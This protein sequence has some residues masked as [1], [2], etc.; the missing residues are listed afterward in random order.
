MSCKLS[1]VH[2]GVWCS[3]STG[4]SNPPGLGSIPKCP[5]QLR[6]TQQNFFD[7]N[8]SPFTIFIVS[9]KIIKQMK[10][11]L[12]ELTGTIVGYLGSRNI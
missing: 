11:K 4:G 9:N 7:L 3:G 8:R 2:T 1:S 5:S 10:K 12:G 6:A